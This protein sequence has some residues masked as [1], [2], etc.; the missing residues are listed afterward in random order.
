VTPIE[1]LLDAE[2]DALAA[3]LAALPAEGW[4]EPSLCAGWQVRHVVSH[5]LMPYEQSVPRF[6]LAMARARFRF[7]AM[8]DRWA[9]ADTRTPR[10]LVAA[11][12]CTAQLPFR[13]PGAPAE[14][15]L[16]H[17]VIHAGDVYRGLGRPHVPDALAAAIVL[18]E[19][20]AAR[21][22][23]ALVPGLLDGL[24]LAA[25]DTDWSHGQGATVTG[26]A[27]A[28]I[29]TLAGRSAA[30]AE[31][32]GDGVPVLARRLDPATASQRSR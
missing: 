12:R 26:P 5:V 22:R 4:E 29:I 17:L 23:R 3:M 16:S 31:L 7:D 21:N 1:H 10:E 15:S 32:S 6:L 2:R 8:A 13:V 20:T 19:L 30:L 11:L 14:A 9:R 18:R 24:C 27:S 25:T 28:L